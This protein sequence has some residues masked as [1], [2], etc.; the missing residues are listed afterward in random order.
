MKQIEEGPRSTPVMAETDVL[1]IGSGP[2]GLAAALSASRE[3][4]KTMLV[5]RY[6]CFGGVIS[7]VGVEGISWYRHE[8]TTDAE[9]IGIE[10]ERRA[11]E[12]GGARPGLKGVKG[13][14]LNAEMFKVVADKM[15]QESN[16][17]PLLHSLA[18]AAIMDGEAI[19]G[20]ITESKSGRQAIL[21]KR[22][23]DATGDADLADRAGR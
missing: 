1:V 16:V 20:V 2:G 21:A 12:L 14:M 15:I 19:K 8:S 11:K 18:V 4:V 7:Q 6:G 23:I 5:D 17:E 10:F 22:V 9:G 13:E 3:G